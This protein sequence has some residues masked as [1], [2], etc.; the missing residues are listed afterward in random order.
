MKAANFRERAIKA[1]FLLL[2]ESDGS[3]GEGT[4]VSDEVHVR[5]A[6]G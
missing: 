5:G 6:V 2:E 3:F 4:D 1:A